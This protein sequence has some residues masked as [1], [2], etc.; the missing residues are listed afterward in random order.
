MAQEIVRQH[1]DQE[2]WVIDGNHI[3]DPRQQAL[4]WLRAVDAFHSE[5]LRSVQ[6]LFAPS[7]A[8]HLEDITSWDTSLIA[9]GGHCWAGA[10]EPTP[11]KIWH[12]A[13]MR[14]FEFVALQV[15]YNVSKPNTMT[16]PAPAVHI[17][18]ARIIDEVDPRIYSGFTEHMGRCIYGGLYDPDNQH[19]LVDP[20]TGFRTDVIDAL[21]ELNIP[22]VHDGIGPKELR[23][24][25]PELA[26]LT[27]ESNQFGT[28]NEVWG[29]WQGNYF[30]SPSTLAP[31]RSLPSVGQM[32]SQ[33]YA[34][35]AYQWAKALK[36]LDPNIKLISC[37]GTSL[38]VFVSAP[39][40]STFYTGPTV[41]KF[42]Q[43]LTKHTPDAAKL[44]KY[45]DV[46]A[47]LSRD[48]REIRVALLNRHEEESFVVPIWFAGGSGSAGVEE[49]VR[50]YEVWS[51][52]LRDG[53]TF[54]EE[55]VRSV[56]R[57]VRFEGSYEIK[58]HSFQGMVVM[59]VEEFGCG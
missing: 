52:N 7:M 23:P 4:E 34:K 33:D 42:V 12:A 11:S 24:R 39:S 32:E 48:G 57:V 40:P 46:S 10:A 35:K 20:M 15:P 47:V 9:R 14:A 31:S 58:R 49:E 19:G 6:V 28:G 56:E 55:R 43:D 2:T 8:A 36:L 26:W 13:R 41:P 27:E 21:R 50:V 45:V 53:N 38:D 44:T 51:E 54:G 16:T 1:A 59:I 22:L 3:S 37:G 17:D 18:P 25:R 5:N 29:P 30:P